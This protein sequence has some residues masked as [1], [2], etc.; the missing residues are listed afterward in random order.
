MKHLAGTPPALFFFS[1]V[2]G[3]SLGLMECRTVYW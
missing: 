2:G 3:G 1:E